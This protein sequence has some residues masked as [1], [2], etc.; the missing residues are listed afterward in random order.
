VDRYT[1]AGLSA[2]GLWSFSVAIGRR[3]TES[4]GTLTAPAMVQVVGAVLCLGL[5][6]GSPRRR[7]EL[8]RASPRYLIGCGLLYSI[9]LV[10]LFGALGLARDRQQAIEM[11][12]VNYLWPPLTV[13]LSVPLLGKRPRWWL[14]AGLGL[15]IAGIWLTLTSQVA[16][17]FGSLAANVAAYPWPYLGALLAAVSWGLYSNLARRWGGAQ[18]GGGVLLFIPVAAVVLGGIAALS[19][20]TPQWSWRS[21]LEVGFLGIS[22]VIAYSC[23][24]L[25]M[26]KGD[27][28]LVA[29]ASYFTPLLATFLACCYLGVTPAWKLSAGCLLLIAGSWLSRTG[30]LEP[31][32]DPLNEADK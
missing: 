15:A 22:S 4:L 1:L 25:A 32:G 23:W 10:G 19:G 18:A 24:D 31:S 13:A 3:V 9:Y 28:V 5:L 8:R 30:V 21:G 14:A 20:E 16:T 29:T 2:I 27:V 6:A 11:G 12:L 26:R 17:T 7:R